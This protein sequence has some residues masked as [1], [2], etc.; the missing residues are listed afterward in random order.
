VTDEIA[1]PALSAPNTIN[2]YLKAGQSNN[3]GGRNPSYVAE[4]A[5]SIVKLFPE[6]GRARKSI[7]Y[8]PGDDPSV[9]RWIQRIVRQPHNLAPVSYGGVLR[10][11]PEISFGRSLFQHYGAA[12]NAVIAK[13]AIGG[14]N[15][16]RDW[17]RS[18]PVS[19]SDRLIMFLQELRKTIEENGD[20]FHLSAFTWLQGEADTKRQADADAYQE[21]L[22]ILIEKVRT[23][24]G[25]KHLPVTIARTHVDVSIAP[26]AAFL[27]AV[28][29]AQEAFVKNDPCAALIN[30]D[31]LLHDATGVHFRASE[32]DIIGA[33]EFEGVF[34]IRRRRAWAPGDYPA[35]RSGT[36]MGE[37]LPSQTNLTIHIGT[38]KTGSSAIQKFC[39][40]QR[41][42]LLARGTLYP[43]CEFRFGHHDLAWALS[44]S[45]RA[46]RDQSLTAEDIASDILAH[47]HGVSHILISSEDFENLDTPAI[48]RLRSL[49]SRCETTVVVYVRRQDSALL[50]IYAQRIT[51]GVRY[52]GTLSELADRLKPRRL[53]Y[54]KLA[55]RWAAVFGTAA[56][57]VRPFERSCFLEGNV[58]PDFLQLVGIE[59]RGLPYSQWLD[60]NK[61]LHPLTLEMLRRLNAVPVEGP[62]RRL[63]RKIETIAAAYPRTTIDFPAVKR[64]AF[65]E[66]FRESN[67]RVAQTWLGR[68]DLFLEEIPEDP[69]FDAT[70][71]I[72]DLL[73][74]TAPLRERA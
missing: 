62:R 73:A 23:F 65:L 4:P 9:P 8:P 11:G 17:M 53:D 35:E 22:Q 39:D 34:D 64:R 25:S 19:L 20:K 16:A 6:L 27:G 21:N 2:V 46:R 66:Q 72:D 3:L 31:D 32:Y 12:H 13:F 15:M 58:I 68:N 7:D 26:K 50:S 61:S 69:S 48:Q 59:A 41:T 52:Q 60:T 37:M 5:D 14:S 45:G 55:S 56:V 51:G 47:A 24:A 57:R 54:W 36:Y 38:H 10:A 33:R 42:E 49:F 70:T 1:V 74:Q 29:A 67:Q 28:R 71:V 30:L 40:N 18:A 63:I 43:R 44:G